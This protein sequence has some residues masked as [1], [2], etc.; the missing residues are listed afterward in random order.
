MCIHQRP[1][2]NKKKEFNS[3]IKNNIADALE[4]HFVSFYK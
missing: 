4:E 2:V 3:S 1:T